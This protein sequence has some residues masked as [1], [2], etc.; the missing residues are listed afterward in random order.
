MKTTPKPL[1]PHARI[2]FFMAGVYTIILA[3]LDIDA[4]VR[5][6]GLS[7][8]DLAAVRQRLLGE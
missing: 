7:Q 1:I 8:A 6:G 2:H 4:Y 3:G 5:A